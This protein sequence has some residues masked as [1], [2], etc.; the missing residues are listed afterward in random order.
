MAKL[1]FDGEV[2]GSD[3][4]ESHAAGINGPI[5]NACSLL[6]ASS[7]LIQAGISILARS[8]TWLDQNHAVP[9]LAHRTALS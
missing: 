5:E 4:G 7:E 1:I 3:R 9:T 2:R 8:L 6:S